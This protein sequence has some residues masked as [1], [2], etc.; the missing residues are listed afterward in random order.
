M[1]VLGLQH[2][3]AMGSRLTT[4]VAPKTG[5][6]FEARM[7]TPKPGFINAPTC[8]IVDVIQQQ[9]QS[10]LGRSAG[11]APL[12]GLPKAVG[13]ELITYRER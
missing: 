8:E 1:R 2:E 11:C 10:R 3:S 4:R 12:R 13:G 7:L 5:L 6:K 9:P